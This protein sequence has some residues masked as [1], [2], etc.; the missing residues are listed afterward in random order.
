[1]GLLRSR[2]ASQAST[3]LY[4]PWKGERAALEVLAGFLK[5]PAVLEEDGDEIFEIAPGLLLGRD[6]G[7]QRVDFLKVE[8]LERLRRDGFL[9]RFGQRLVN[10]GPHLFVGELGGV[11]GLLSLAK[12]ASRSSALPQRVGKQGRVECFVQPGALFRSSV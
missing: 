5:S 9:H 12:N 8:I 4:F 6:R 7:D 11:K 10:A 3:W 1:M 2:R